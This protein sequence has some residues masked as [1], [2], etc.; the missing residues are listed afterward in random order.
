MHVC[1]GLTLTR[2]SYYI[3]SLYAVARKTDGDE[4]LC[5]A[6]FYLI[7]HDLPSLMY[8]FSFCRNDFYIVILT[9]MNY[10]NVRVC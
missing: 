2:V 7:F 1:Q 6:L 4:V 10:A 9:Q 8:H 5:G 3:Q